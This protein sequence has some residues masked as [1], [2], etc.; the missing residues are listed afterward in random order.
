M[1]LNPNIKHHVFSP[2]ELLKLADDLTKPTALTELAV[3]AGC[4]FIAWGIARLVRGSQVLQGSIWFGQRIVDG[5]FFPVLAALLGLGARELLAGEV[6]IA[7]FKLAIPILTSLALIR[8]T[9]RVLQAAFPNSHLMR[10]VERS[11]SW[12]AWVVVVLWITGVM[13][14]LLDEMDAISWK[15]GATQLTLRNVIEG[16]LSAITVLIVSLW[17]SSVLET[18]LLRGAAVQDLSTRKI[19]A[20]ALR[21]VM[22][23]VG[24]LM[25]LSA[26][27]IDLTALSVLS[28]AVGVGLGFGLQKLASNYV[29]GFVILAERA[30]RIGDL[31]KVDSFEGRITDISTRYT[32]IRAANGRESL[33][34]N[35]LLITQRVENASRADTKTMLQ[36][37]LQVPYGTDVDALRSQLTAAVLEVQRV[38]RDPEPVVQFSNFTPDGLEL[39]VQFWIADPDKN[40][41]TVRSDANL[42]ILRVLVAAGIEVPRPQRVVRQIVEGS[43]TSGPQPA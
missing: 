33:V 37:V 40:Q 34:P 43:S 7:V 39:T 22:L 27:G 8:L 14:W 6:P 3:L 17:L 23:F 5:V 41:L 24:L 2:D 12:G 10:V 4:L 38:V 11:F 15:V 20:N 19:A 1:A 36:S 32:V 25:A 30:L 21:A 9:V 13:P 18:R 31:V 16:S 26:A 35:E 29:S 28:G 42:A